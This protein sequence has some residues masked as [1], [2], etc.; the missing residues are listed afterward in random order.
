MLLDG[1]R[2][3]NAIRAEVA[4][5][6]VAFQAA[7]NR[8]PALHIVLVGDD[9][10]SQ[11]YVR[12]KERAG[13]DAGLRV[14]VHRLAATSTVDALLETVRS[15]NA[16]PECDGAVLGL[17]MDD[18][19]RYGSLEI[20]A[21]GWL[22]GFREKRPGAS[23]IN[24][25]VYLIRDAL[26]AAFPLKRPLSWETDVFPGLLAAGRKLRVVRA[27]APFLDIGLPETLAAAGDFIQASA[28]AFA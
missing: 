22:A 6:V 14:K 5:R 18:A 21:E 27:K 25:G 16:D 9:P 15:L 23:W 4:P 2:V 20:T 28:E 8:P 1:T 12:N 10:A 13:T 19:S 3:A 17:W 26:L 7:R 24:A 11:I